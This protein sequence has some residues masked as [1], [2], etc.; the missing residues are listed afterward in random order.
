M[1]MGHSNCCTV[2]KETECR[3]WTST[4]LLPEQVYFTDFSSGA[5]LLTARVAVSE[6]LERVFIEEHVP[7]RIGTDQGH[8]LTVA[9]KTRIGGTKGYF[10][11]D[12][13]GTASTRTAI[14]HVAT[15]ATTKLLTVEE[16]PVTFA[17]CQDI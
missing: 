14:A 2:S 4:R 9:L 1:I 12:P 10:D 7:C 3:S 15:E 6:L 5:K 11:G 8:R 13:I 16:E 17:E